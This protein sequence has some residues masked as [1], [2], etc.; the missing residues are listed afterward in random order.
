[1]SPGSLLCTGETEKVP[2]RGS[3]TELSEMP[4]SLLFKRNAEKNEG[5]YE[6]FSPADDST[7]SGAF[8]LPSP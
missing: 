6:I 2:V 7:A 4:N 8:S 1:M 3:K 5:D